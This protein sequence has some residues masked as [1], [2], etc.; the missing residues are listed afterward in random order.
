MSYTLDSRDMQSLC[1]HDPSGDLE[2]EASLGQGL[3]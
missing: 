1:T 3:L 2:K